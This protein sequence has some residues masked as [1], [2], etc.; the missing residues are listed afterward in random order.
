M[1]VSFETNLIEIEIFFCLNRTQIIIIKLSL[2]LIFE[3][4]QKFIIAS[5]RLLWSK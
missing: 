3:T 5:S 1:F 4:W 2:K